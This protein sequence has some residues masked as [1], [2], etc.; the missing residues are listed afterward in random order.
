MCRH[1]LLGNHCSC[2]VI[3]SDEQE[4]CVDIH[5]L[6]TIVVAV[7]LLQMEDEQEI[8]VDTHCLGT[9]VVAVSLLQMSKIYV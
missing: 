2:C 1:T 3:T 7:S 6:G 9:I 4:M 8:C 5:C